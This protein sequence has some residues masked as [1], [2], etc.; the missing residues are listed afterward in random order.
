MRVTLRGEPYL[1]WRVADRHGAELDI[2]LQEQRD[3]AEAKRFFKRVLANTCGAG[4]RKIV[5]DRLRNYQAGNAEMPE[6]M[7]VKQM[8]AR[9]D[10]CAHN[11]RAEN[12]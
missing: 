9:Q 6:L 8:F 3:Q 4:P 7:N 11:N 10:H 1:L 2:L 12:S 5:I